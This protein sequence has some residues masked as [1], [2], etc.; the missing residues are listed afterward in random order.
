MESPYK[1]AVYLNATDAGDRQWGESFAFRPCLCG[2]L[3]VSD[4]SLGKARCSDLIQPGS[5]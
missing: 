4:G 3:R 5:S 2:F 1:E